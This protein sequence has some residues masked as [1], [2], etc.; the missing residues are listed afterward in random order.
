MLCVFDVNETLLDLAPLDEVFLEL[1]GSADARREWFAL[2][3]HTALSVTAA[4]GYRDF[5][6]IAGAAAGAI[7]GRH[8]RE[9][10]DEQRKKVG[11]T[12]RSLPPHPEV[13]GALARLRD[14]GFTLVALA[15]SPLATVE[16]QLRHA[17]L[18]GLFDGIFSAQQA[19]ALKPAA[20]PYRQVLEAHRAEPGEAMM[21]AAHDWDIA[22]AQAAGLRTAFLGRPGQ[23][24]LPGAAGPTMTAPDL[25]AL[26]DLLLT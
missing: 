14:G 18:T 1:T 8:G 11:A 3:I 20:A 26:A 22:G 25:A 5:A 12:L 10:S 17:G 2:V 7:V 6:E 24:L 19:G 16:A 23:E 13:P 21:I 15:N 9:A 4:G